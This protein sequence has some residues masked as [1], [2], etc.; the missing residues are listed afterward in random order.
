MGA[1]YTGTTRD[2]ACS[3]CGAAMGHRQVQISDG[4]AA[5]KAYVPCTRGLATVTKEAYELLEAELREEQRYHVERI[6]DAW[7]ARD[8]AI[9]EAREAG[10]LS[11]S[12][13]ENLTATQA[14]CTKLLEEARTLRARVARVEAER[15]DAERRLR[16][17][18]P[19]WGMP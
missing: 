1:L 18:A 16:A 3:E 6:C 11:L 14:K 10:R 15:D 7:L 9:E 2:G 17:A 8:A 5:V 13:L 19:A 4:H 12:Y